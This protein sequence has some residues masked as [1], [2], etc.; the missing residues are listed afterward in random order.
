MHRGLCM[1]W[2]VYTKLL[3]TADS[4]AMRWYWRREL[5]EGAEESTEGF[6]SRLQCEADAVQHGCRTEEQAQE[7]RITMS[8]L[9]WG[10]DFREREEQSRS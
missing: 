2:R 8:R 10:A 3:R 9:F 4:V 7:R 6:A 1:Q 5:P